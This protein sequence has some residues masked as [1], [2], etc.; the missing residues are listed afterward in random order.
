M[1]R[2][3]FFTS[4]FAAT[5][6]A[7]AGT[8]FAQCSLPNQLQNG[9]LADA[10]KVTANFT[11]LADCADNKVPTGN[12]NSIIYNAGNGSLGGASPLSDGQLLIGST[13][14]PPQAGAILAGSGIAVTGGPASLTISATGS[15]TGA[16]VDWL[17]KSAVAKPAVSSFTMRTSTTVPTGASLSATTRGILLSVASSADNRA[18]MAETTL[19]A[20]N[21]QA[22]ML[23]IYTGPLSSYAQPSITV[24]DATT[25]RAV[26]FA[27]GGGG[28]SSYRF[29]YVRTSGG[30]GLDSVSGDSPFQDIGFPSPSEPIWSRLTY[31][32]TT[33]VWSFSRDGENFT[34]AYSVSATDWLGQRTTIGPAV[35]FFQPSHPSWNSG[36][37]IMSWNL[38]AL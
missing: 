30:V 14:N 13:D 34:T 3:S 5:F 8:A 31:N 33:L 9:D 20:G 35:F 15:G 29:D 6:V 12:A 24:R 11:A 7:T 36:Y 27:L 37:H 26:S 4:V 19:P 32:G 16:A 23:G 21:W 25:N 2:V 28:S 38:A 18:I 10:A 22:T 1:P 17:N